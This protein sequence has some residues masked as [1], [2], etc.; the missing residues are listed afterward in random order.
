MGWQAAEW[1]EQFLYK[2]RKMCDKDHQEA[3]AVAG[4]GFKRRR[5]DQ[6]EQAFEKAG[7]SHAASVYEAFQ[8]CCNY[9]HKVYIWVAPTEVN[10]KR[11][12]SW[13]SA[14]QCR[15]RKIHNDFQP[16]RGL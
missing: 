12:L 3:V 9:H 11:I 7:A 1:S 16:H 8:I 2:A 15:T 5:E 10:Q 4:L 6:L 14:K 13:L